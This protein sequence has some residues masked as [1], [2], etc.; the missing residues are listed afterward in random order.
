MA[1][2]RA[3]A[4]EALDANAAAFEKSRKDRPG[5]DEKW[6][7]QVLSSGTLTDKVAA[8]GL[9]VSSNPLENLRSLD[10]L[11]ALAKKF[12]WEKKVCRKCYARL[13]VR[14][15]NCRKKACGHSNNLRMKKKLK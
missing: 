3:R 10:T 5:G 2:V 1:A 6:L 11:V 7:R 13:P 14:A 9:L 15:T 8:M 12:N 4:Q